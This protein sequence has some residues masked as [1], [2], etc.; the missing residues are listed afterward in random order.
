VLTATIIVL[1]NGNLVAQQL[2]SWI[3]AAG[4]NGLWI[5]LAVFPVVTAIAALLLYIILKP[6]LGRFAPSP[7]RRAPA[8]AGADEGFAPGPA[9]EPVAPPARGPAPAPAALPAT[10]LATA[11]RGLVRTVPDREPW[12]TVAVALEMGSADAAVLD[13]VRDQ[14]L[15]TRT[16]LVLLHVVESAAGRY[17]GPETS[18]EESREDRSA[19]EAIAD[20]FR[21]L[22]IASE[23]R[24]GFGNPAPELARMIEEAGA[25]LVITGSHGHRLIGDLIHGATISALR[26][27]VRCRVLTV[28]GG[29]PRRT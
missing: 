7:L 4:P 14:E 11:R 16:R 22:G 15:T 3:G 23:V 24:L 20:R 2:T 9:L 28:P 17:L 25:D 18:D 5:R 1:L 12:R 29:A 19:L 26:H 21:A 6:L 13:H 10:A 27:L 8:A